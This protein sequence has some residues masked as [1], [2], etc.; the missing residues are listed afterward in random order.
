MTIDECITYWAMILKEPLTM[1]VRGS[2]VE[3]I[4]LTNAKKW[5][6]D[7]FKEMDKI[8]DFCYYVLE[9]FKPTSVS[10]YPTNGHLT[11]IY[12]GSRDYI[13]FKPTQVVNTYEPLTL[14]EGA[15]IFAEK[16]GVKMEPPE[17]YDL[18]Q[19]KKDYKKI[20]FHEMLKKYGIRI[21]G[22][23]ASEGAFKLDNVKNKESA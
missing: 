3:N 15:K 23:I 5:F 4:I 7:N 18:E 6:S 22:H 21:A 20:S 2:K 19:A 1:N 17:N 14:E 13:A 12:K 11:E 9:S 16:N 10:P 8:Q